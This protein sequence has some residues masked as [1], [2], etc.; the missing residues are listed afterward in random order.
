M[1]FDEELKKLNESHKAWERFKKSS[2]SQ[3]DGFNFEKFLKENKISPEEF[4]NY[5]EEKQSLLYNE[6]E[7]LKNK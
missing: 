2:S 1:N 5:T 3:N 7:I 6:Y 4:D